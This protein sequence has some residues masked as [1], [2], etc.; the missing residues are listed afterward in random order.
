YAQ[1]WALS[2]LLHALAISAAVALVADVHLVP[3]QEPFKWEVAVVE[4]A[5]TPLPSQ[6]QPIEKPAQAQANPVRPTSPTQ[7]IESP[8]AKATPIETRPATQVAQ[9]L[10]PT[11]AVSTPPAPRQETQAPQQEI[12]KTAPIAQTP[13]R[14]VEM[15][16]GSTEPVTASSSPPA[17][18]E[19][20]TTAKAHAVPQE[21]SQTAHAAPQAFANPTPVSPPVP[22]EVARTVMESSPQVAVPQPVQAP[23]EQ[24]SAQEPPARSVSTTKTDYGWLA[25][26]LW[27]RVEQ[28]K[29][30]PQQARMNRW[31]GKV[32]LR[33]VIRD[34]GHLL[35]LT[36]MQSSGHDVLDHDA[37]EIM[38][39]A[40][41]LTLHH[42]LGRPQVV[43]QVPISYRLE[44]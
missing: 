44:R 19:A 12:K 3:Q 9:P 17:T 2:V 16:R 43:V 20:R 34:D 31:E 33:A 41:P 30:Y 29:H 38:K 26:A 37:L 7:T 28:L 42:P 23:V 32:V 40:S 11:P 39:R 22:P 10:S 4:T 36:I 8:P 35:D 6:S 27:S 13:S 5:E 21:P 24:A 15:E 1:G 25:K 18:D 14:P